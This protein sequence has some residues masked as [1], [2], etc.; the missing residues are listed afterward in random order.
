MPIQTAARDLRDKLRLERELRAQVD[1]YHKTIVARFDESLN[2]NEFNASL[3]AILTEH[4]RNVSDIFSNRL[5]SQLPRN[6]STT[7]NERRTIERDLNQ[8][9]AARAPNQAQRIN[10]TTSDDITAAFAAASDDELVRE[11]VGLEAE[12][13]KKT[14]ATAIFSRK[15]TA[16]AG[17][18]ASTETQAV[19]ET[20]KATEAEVLSGFEPSIT[21]PT[22]HP[23]QVMKEWVSVGDS[24]VRTGT[25][26]HL[27]ADGQRRPTNEP[28]V[29][30]GE[31]LMHP[32]D[33]SRGASVGNVINC[34][35]SAVYDVEEVINVRSETL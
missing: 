14:I 4:Y 13:T 27:T 15:L 12:I 16:R 30:S 26:D 21:S 17:S 34:R 5:G 28:F 11:L 22:R 29:V 7:D 10:K 25:F 23:S 18:I 2:M 20:A 3:T 33:T 8:W 32:G 6:V 9:I 19:A 35:C 24:V 31:Q 1:A